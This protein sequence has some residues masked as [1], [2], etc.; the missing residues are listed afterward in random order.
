MH[1]AFARP[2]IRPSDALIAG[3]IAMAQFV[4]GAWLPLPSLIA[5]TLAMVRLLETLRVAKPLLWSAATASA[6]AALIELSSANW[7][8]TLHL[9][10]CLMAV[11]MVVTRSPRAMMAWLGIAIALNLLAILIAPFCIAIAIRRRASLS[12]WLTAPVVLLAML[13]AQMIVSGAPPSL[14]IFATGDQAPSIWSLVALIGP[15][16]LPSLFAL[17]VALALGSIAW[18]IARLQIIPLTDTALVGIATLTVLLAALLSPGLPLQSVLLAAPLSLAFALATGTRR[19]LALAVMVHLGIAAAATPPLAALAAGCMIAA[20]WLL[21]RPLLQPQANDNPAPPKN[22]PRTGYVH[23]AP[24]ARP[25]R[26]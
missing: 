4:D 17:A 16:Y 5:L 12:A 19:N 26:L 6:T 2:A 10:A 23:R 7:G 24:P 1:T 18:L 8:G 9:G 13:A 21:A 11:A 3:A 22:W 25:F 14:P 15:E 20:G